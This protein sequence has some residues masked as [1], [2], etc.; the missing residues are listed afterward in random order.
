MSRTLR[1]QVS[2]LAG[3]RGQQNFSNIIY[4]TSIKKENKTQRLV[5]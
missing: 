2:A 3:S 5:E 1:R 4:I